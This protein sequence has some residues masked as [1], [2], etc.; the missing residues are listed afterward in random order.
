MSNQFAAGVKTATNKISKLKVKTKKDMKD[1]LYLVQGSIA[2][3]SPQFTAEKQ[4]MVKSFINQFEYQGGANLPEPHNALYPQIFKVMRQQA[5]QANAPQTDAA[6]LSAAS[7]Y[8]YNIEKP[9]T[10]SASPASYGVKQSE[11]QSSEF[12]SGQKRRWMT[13]GLLGAS[14][15][16][17]V[18]M[19]Y[20]AFRPKP[21]RN[22]ERRAVTSR[23]KRQKASG[24][25]KSR[26]KS[27]NRK[28]RPLRSN[29]STKT[30]A[31][32]QYKK[33]YQSTKR[34]GLKLRKR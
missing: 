5:Q 31:L 19:L 2:M 7:W 18:A 6:I 32:S 1:L 22:P 24:R 14:G 13:F 30:S 4:Q 8:Y 12:K 21:K 3:E 17:G 28:K 11:T 15:L 25:I 23:T 9:K 10:G 26:R 20:F 27:L 34:K 33:K 16:F 29:Q